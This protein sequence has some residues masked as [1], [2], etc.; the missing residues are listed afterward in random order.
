M[1]VVSV[2]KLFTGRGGADNL[3]KRRVY[4][5]VWE[6]V[7]NSAS[8]GEQV[9]A[10]AA[11]V[12]PLGSSHPVDAQAIVTGVD[13]DQSEDTPFLWLVRVTYDSKPDFP[14][15]LDPQTGQTLS[16]A[17]IP[18]NPLDRPAV[19]EFSFVATSEPA[20]KWRKIINDVP[21]EAA[22]AITNS[23]GMP[24]DPPVM[25][26]VARP[27]IRV[28]KNVA[29]VTGAFLNQLEG[30]INDRPWRGLNKW[31]ARVSGV[32]AGNKWENEIPFVELA[33]EIA[34][35]RETWALE[36]LDAGMWEKTVVGGANK[37]TQIVDPFGAPASEPQPLNGTGQKLA[38]GL[39]PNYL[40]G[41]P[42]VYHEEDFATLLNL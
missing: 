25:V 42:H 40:R 17:E 15:A 1:A 39:A 8:D 30:A 27:V 2:D 24:F 35:R 9:V 12:P 10:N 14:N 32:R 36:V 4:R 34:I 19:W 11:G 29:S 5:E 37:Y 16:P 7:T 33:I 28:T 13:A 6:V 23:A 38:P 18:A 22:E 20:V 31:C 26:E 41:L 21:G 3:Q